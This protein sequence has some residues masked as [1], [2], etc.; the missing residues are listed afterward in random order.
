MPGSFDWLPSCAREH[1]T[2]RWYNVGITS[3][4][5]SPSSSRCDNIL[6][7]PKFSSVSGMPFF[8][9][10]VPVY[11]AVQFPGLIGTFLFLHLGKALERIRA[12]CKENEVRETQRKQT[13]AQFG[14]KF[15][16]G[17]QKGA[18]WTR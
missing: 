6:F 16:H 1:I 17:G 7:I 15:A 18:A 14:M 13:V 9:N 4:I 8:S 10:A 3:C 5:F 2:D 12:I 11:S